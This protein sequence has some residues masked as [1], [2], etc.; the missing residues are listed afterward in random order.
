[1][2][3][4]T[5]AISGAIYDVVDVYA[6]AGE[7][8]DVD[9][10]FATPITAGEYTIV[11]SADAGITFSDFQSTG[12]IGPVSINDT[13]ITGEVDMDCVSGAF[14]TLE[15]CV[16][17]DA[18]AGTYNIYATVNGVEAIA[19]SITIC[20]HAATKTVIVKAASCDEAGTANTVCTAC[21]TVIATAEVEA[22]GHS[23]K[24]FVIAPTCTEGGYTRHICEC[25]SDAYTD[26][27]VEALGHAWD[28]GTVTVEP[29]TT[30]QGQIIYTCT[31]CGTQNKV[32]LPKIVY[33][34]VNEDGNVTLTDATLMLQS[35][36]K[37]NLEGKTFNKVN[38]DVNCDT[39]I[40]LND[41]AMVLKYIAKWDVTF[42]PAK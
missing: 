22:A 8:V 10:N 19:G 9:I 20:D 2:P 31:T 26:N 25:C 40:N 6:T 23:Y 11:V 36:A 24:D 33:G 27:V 15:F 5:V 7:I 4:E 32:T 17:D 35:I 28:E 16:A 37:W 21:G 39:N 34:D 38:A 3:F 41:V 30:K 14:G 1:L 12:A 42:G 13:T 18:A 29:S